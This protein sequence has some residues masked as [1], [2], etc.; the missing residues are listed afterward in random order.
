VRDVSEHFTLRIPVSTSERLERR[1]ARTGVAKRT[2]AQRYLEEGLRH[3]DHP[4]VHFVAGPTG[5]RAALVGTGLDVWEVV[6][7]VQDHDGNIG[8][9][10]D[11][12]SVPVGVVQAAVSY[13]GEFRDEIDDEIAVN[14]EEWE[15]GRS[16]WEAG[17]RAVR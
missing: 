13:Y 11:Y 10:A 5:R 9:S 15:R 7:T 8:E 17:R 4:L 6:A 2:M 12:L 16:A 14:D 3:D 1:S